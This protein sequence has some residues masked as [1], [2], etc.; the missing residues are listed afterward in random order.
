MNAA[1]RIKMG[2]Q[3]AN[4]ILT[5]AGLGFG[6]LPG[7]IA[8]KVIFGSGKVGVLPATLAGKAFIISATGHKIAIDLAAGNAF[9]ETCQAYAL[10][11]ARNG[12]SQNGQVTFTN[13]LGRE[14]GKCQLSTTNGNLNVTSKVW[15]WGHAVGI[16]EW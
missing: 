5:V 10:C 8:G 16:Y 15:G 11:L 9:N 7:S 3:G 2:L 13:A 4:N 1:F 14:I 12:L 6:S